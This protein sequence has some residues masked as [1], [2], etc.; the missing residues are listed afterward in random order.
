[1]YF[2][3]KMYDFYFLFNKELSYD[4]KISNFNAFS[5]SGPRMEIR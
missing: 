4:G 3:V 1:M 2:G 5:K